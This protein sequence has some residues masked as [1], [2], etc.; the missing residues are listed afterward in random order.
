MES[1]ETVDIDDVIPR[2]GGADSAISVPEK[3]DPRSKLLS[4]I[5]KELSGN[6]D[7]V[8]SEECP[9]SSLSVIK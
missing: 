5:S 1:S 7:P 6:V 9:S 4:A 3:T 2:Q 8:D